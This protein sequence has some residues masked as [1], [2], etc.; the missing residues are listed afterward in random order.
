MDPYRYLPQ[1]SH[2]NGGSMRPVQH[3]QLP[4]PGRYGSYSSLG[5]PCSAEI[6]P[7]TPA[8]GPPFHETKVLHKISTR[9][10][11]QDLQPDI[12]CSIKKGFF[13]VDN[14]WTCYRR[15]Y[16]TV[17]CGFTIK[18]LYPAGPL[19]LTIDHT[20][21]P[22]LSF[23]VSISAKTSAAG[24]QD[25]E[26]RGLVQHTPK[27]DKETESVPGQHVI[28]P[29]PLHSMQHHGGSL[30][31]QPSMYHGMGDGPVSGTFGNFDTGNQQVP[32]PGHTFERIQFQ[33]ATANNGK[34]RAQQQY[35]QVVVHLSALIKM[36][37]GRE[38]WIEIATK[39]SDPVVVR[40][41]SPGH[42]KDNGR[43]DSQTSM[44]RDRG[45]GGGSSE[46]SSISYPHSTTHH[47]PSGMDWNYSGRGQHYQHPGA[48]YRTFL[49]SEDSPPSAASS[50]T[51][52]GT[53]DETDFALSEA[54]TLKSSDVFDFDRSRL[55]PGSEIVDETLFSASH[56]IVGR[57][58]PLE[59][60]SADAGSA[61]HFHQP[62]ADAFTVH[63]F[64][65]TPV[66][67]SKALCP[68]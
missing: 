40:G 68:S 13:Q 43:R 15:N 31:M 61:Y 56:T 16:F 66:A 46:G 10:G 24:N 37:N 52:T 28:S 11:R 32:P 41:R 35:F 33:K 49:P 20:A 34:R 51:L 65:M 17:E 12:I 23:A 54:D 5:Y 19:Y 18:E 50:T 53:P 25:S 7:P 67:R 42:Y 30:G 60:D 64:D 8:E 29:A 45:A 44:D 22:I 21:E 27:R 36:R 47:H 2:V 59:D 6:M 39:E 55:T 63:G 62:L 1:T 4:L 38:S 48:T 14:K 57:K 26:A 3:P 9:P 58:R